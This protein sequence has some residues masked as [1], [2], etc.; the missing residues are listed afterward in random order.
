MML[1]FGSNL[2]FKRRKQGA[3]SWTPNPSKKGVADCYRPSQFRDEDHLIEN[4]KTAKG[5]GN[6]KG[7]HPATADADGDIPM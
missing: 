4:A 7:K 1:T 5:K 3:D 6:G 2:I